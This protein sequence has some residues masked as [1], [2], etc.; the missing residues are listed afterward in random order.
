MEVCLQRRAVAPPLDG[1]EMPGVIERLREHEGL[2]AVLGP[3]RG[4]GGLHRLPHARSLRY[5]GEHLDVDDDHVALLQIALDGVRVARLGPVG[6]RAC[7]AQSTALAEQV[8]ALVE[9]ERHRLQSLA[10]GG[11]R[12]L[13]DGPLALVGL[14]RVLLGDERL[15][16]AMNRLVVHLRPSLADYRLPDQ[17]GAVARALRRRRAARTAAVSVSTS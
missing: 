8:P 13:A 6:A 2:T 4:L 17:A 10:V 16:A 7:V 12:I 15:D 14:Q 5:L 11:Q 9:F 1:E 3:G